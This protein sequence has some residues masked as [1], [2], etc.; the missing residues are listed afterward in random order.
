MRSMLWRATAAVAVFLGLQ[1]PALAGETLETVQD[2]GTVLCGV[3]ELGRALSTMNA[4]GDWVGFY[5]DICRAIA[6]A[7]T[8]GADGVE[9]VMVSTADR[10]EALTAG[11]IDVLVEP[12]TWTLTRDTMGMDFTT[13]IF[14]DGQGFLTYVK[15]GLK[16][17]ADLS[18]RSVCVQGRSTSVD[19]LVELNNA[20]GLNLDIQEFRTIEGAYSAFFGRRC[21]AL[22]TDSLI[23]ASMRASLAPNPEDYVLLEE[24]VSHEPLAA[25]VR[26]DDPR[27]EDVVRWTLNALIAAERLGITAEDAAAAETPADRP[28]VARLLNDGALA[29][30]LG[31]DADWARR[32]VAAAGNYA[33]IYERSIGAESGLALPRGRNALVEDG[34]LIWAPPLR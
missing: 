14:H 32:A 27:W 34:G 25:A 4:E 30:R 26:D 22:S 15:D 13:T 12:T 10:F 6:A 31:L 17:V 24:R 9:Y 3:T 5:P 23:L 19:N 2:R 33:E 8:G 20:R 21:A 28:D 1:A 16:S 29:E 18:G 11:A 7:T